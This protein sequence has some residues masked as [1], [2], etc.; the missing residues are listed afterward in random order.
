MGLGA[1][2]HYSTM[3]PQELLAYRE[4]E[5]EKMEKKL[6]KYVLICRR[7]KVC[8]FMFCYVSWLIEIEISFFLFGSKKL[9]SLVSAGGTHISQHCRILINI[10][11]CQVKCNKETIQNDDITKGIIELI[12]LHGIIKLVVG[13]A[14]DKNYSKY[15]PNIYY[16]LKFIVPSTLH[17]PFFRGRGL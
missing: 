1:N 11:L 4:H 13:A 15:G 5:R 7:L 2:V 8:S 14:S 12:S 9:T 17:P 3:R 10:F 16:C 6:N